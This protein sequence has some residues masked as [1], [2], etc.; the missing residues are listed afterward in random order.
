MASS[1]S[2]VL[3]ESRLKNTR[4]TRSSKR[5]PRSNASI[6]LAKLGAASEPVI[7]V[8]SAICSAMPRSKPGGKCSGRMRSKGGTPNGAVQVSKKGLLVIRLSGWTVPVRML[9][10]LADFPGER[11]HSVASVAERRRDQHVLVEA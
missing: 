7:A 8:I 9:A 2:L 6:V 1:S 5:P 11:G 3:L 4:L 10:L